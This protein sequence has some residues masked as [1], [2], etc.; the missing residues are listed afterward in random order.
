MCDVSITVHLPK[1]KQADNVSMS[2]QLQAYEQ[3]NDELKQSNVALNAKVSILE[4]RILSARSLLLNLRAKIF[5]LTMNKKICE[6]YSQ[7]P[8][9]TMKPE[10]TEQYSAFN[11]TMKPIKPFDDDNDESV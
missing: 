7:F 9:I 5:W 2:Q 8:P 10:Y 1:C 3:S 4:G 11:F 6:E